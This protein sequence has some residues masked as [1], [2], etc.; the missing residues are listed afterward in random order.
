[1]NTYYYK[2][3]KNLQNCKLSCGFESSSVTIQYETKL[4]R[5]TALYALPNV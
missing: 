5:N 4:A 1:M 3:I 2:T